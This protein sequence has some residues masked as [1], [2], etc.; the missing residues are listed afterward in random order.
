MAKLI[1][2]E[3][4][5]DKVYE[6]VDD[7]FTI[8]SGPDA[9]LQLRAEGVAPLHVTVQRT[10]AGFRLI[11]METREGTS[12]NG[13]TVNEH[14]LANGDTIQV[15]G[16]KITYIGKGPTRAAAAAK[17]AAPK[18]ESSK[19]YRHAEPKKASSAQ[20]LIVAL[21]A[22]G[23]LILILWVGGFFGAPPKLDQQQ[24]ELAEAVRLTEEG[25]TS[26]KVKEKVPQVLKKY[27][28]QSDLDDRQ[29][30]LY[31]KLKANWDL[32]QQNLGNIEAAKQ[33][34]EEFVAL[35]NSKLKTPDAY[36]LH[37][38]MAK[39]WLAKYE[40]LSTPELARV[41]TMLEELENMRTASPEDK[42]MLRV[43]GM[44]LASIQDKEL[45]RGQRALNEMDPKVRT[46]HPEFVDDMTRMLRMKSRQ[47][48]GVRKN[49]V[50]EY[51]RDDKYDPARARQ[52]AID[53]IF[54]KLI[55]S[56]IEDYLASP[57]KYSQANNQEAE[58][59]T[60]ALLRELLAQMKPDY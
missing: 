60:Q 22:V 40:R 30:A 13:K 23:G 47:W 5:R 25:A 8:G 31:K 32:I 43:K 48:L 21:A 28:N 44:I 59:K 57:D 56:T 12:V 55:Y 24:S 49:D 51:L 53:S 15:A 58:L 18:L 33:A 41:K 36:D 35:Y 52:I 37:E 45:Q 46:G 19:Y 16:V 9:D 39:D 14:V 11:D 6:I 1:I 3:D 50:R 2:T 17:K 7:R 29:K 4:G 42:E 20:L 54:T 26:D 27:A 10:K 34:Q 38:K